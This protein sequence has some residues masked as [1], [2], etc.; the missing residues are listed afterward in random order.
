MPSNKA[1]L[2]WLMA[3]LS[4]LPTLGQSQW[5]GSLQLGR[6]LQ[7]NPVYPTPTQNSSLLEVAYAPP[8]GKHLWQQLFPGLSHAFRLHLMNLGNPQSLGY[9]LGMT[10][11]LEQRLLRRAKLP[12]ELHLLLAT[13]LGYTTRPYQR[14]SNPDNNALGSAFNNLTRLGLRASYFPDPRLGIFLQLGY[15]HFSNGR[16]AVPNLGLN[17]PNL[18]LGLHYRPPQQAVP[19]S[20]AWPEFLPTIPPGG[21]D[22]RLSL[23]LGQGLT[24]AP[25]PNGPS[26]AVYLVSADLN[27]CNV[28]P[29]QRRRRWKVGTEWFLNLQSYAL[30]RDYDHDLPQNLWQATGGVVFVGVEWLFG[31]TA[32]VAQ[33]GPYLKRAFQMNYFLYTKLGL[34]YYLYDQQKRTHRQP[35]VGVYVHAHSGESDFA[36]FSLGWMF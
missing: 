30:L 14:Q 28:H 3:C 27:F 29:D 13:G 17:I 5:S 32:V 19:Q 9:G 20:P 8:A 35:F 21:V 11:D 24:Q 33:A 22:M 16:V 15:T 18:G 10:L 34:K 36:E 31:R 1:L 26:Y 2:F 7:I 25:T 12:V 6:V 4:G 23:R